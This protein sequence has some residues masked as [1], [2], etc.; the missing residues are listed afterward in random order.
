[1]VPYCWL[2]SVIN[3]HQFQTVVA[4]QS[5]TTPSLAL[6]SKLQEIS[7]SQSHWTL[8]HHNTTRMQI[9]KSET[10]NR[11]ITVIILMQSRTMLSHPEIQKDEKDE[12]NAI[13]AQKQY[14]IQT[15]QK[16]INRGPKSSSL[17]PEVADITDSPNSQ[18]AST[19][20]MRMMMNEI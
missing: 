12:K 13:A 15:D 11:H 18:T 19:T 4:L 9:F 5:C 1:M 2:W 14:A 17:I 8:Q 6:S 20:V 3:Q 7:L 16:Q 10:L